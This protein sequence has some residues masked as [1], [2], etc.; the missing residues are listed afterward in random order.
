MRV[1]VMSGLHYTPGG[2]ISHLYWL[3]RYKGSAADSGPDHLVVERVHLGG[4]GGHVLGGPP[5]QHPHQ[6]AGARASQ[7]SA[8]CCIQSSCSAQLDQALLDAAREAALSELHHIVN[9]AGGDQRSVELAHVR[10]VAKQLSDGRD[11]IR[12]LAALREHGGD[13]REEVL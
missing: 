13:Q 3:T 11:A 8:T 10:D 2:L 4:R 9:L 6:N 1:A 12:S 5:P 7:R